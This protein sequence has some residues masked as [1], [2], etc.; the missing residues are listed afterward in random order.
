MAANPP[1]DFP[2]VF[3]PKDFDLQELQKQLEIDEQQEKLTGLVEITNLDMSKTPV[4]EFKKLL[5]Q[6][7]INALRFNSVTFSSDI[8]KLF[9]DDENLIDISFSGCFF[10][11]YDSKVSLSSLLQALSLSQVQSLYFSEMIFLSQD[12]LECANMIVMN[13]NLKSLR[14]LLPLSAAQSQ[15]SDSDAIKYAE[16]LAENSAITEFCLYLANLG[17]IRETG[18]WVDKFA[19][20]LANHKSLCK[21]IQ[22]GWNYGNEDG[23]VKIIEAI[24]KNKNFVEFSLMECRP[25]MS[26]KAV[27]ALMDMVKENVKLTTLKLHES[28]TY[29]CLSILFEIFNRD[30]NLNEFS[31]LS[32]TELE[33]MS[34]EELQHVYDFYEL[35]SKHLDE[36]K[37]MTGSNL[38]LDWEPF[39][40]SFDEQ[41]QAVVNKIKSLAE[42]IN[43]KFTVNRINARHDL[44]PTE[45]ANQILK[46]TQPG[47]FKMSITPVS[48][49][50]HAAF[51]IRQD[52]KAD[53]IREHLNAEVAKLTKTDESDKSGK[54][55]LAAPQEHKLSEEPL[56]LKLHNVVSKA[57]EKID[58]E[59]EEEYQN[60]SVMKTN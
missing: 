3:Q 36:N 35:L 14:I 20:M 38:D 50:K 32:Y 37:I 33:N 9:R 17:P 45:K 53:L 58:Y 46:L 25:L 5:S 48:L 34:L 60:T 55:E 2:L 1:F 44:S 31:L 16:A 30:N 12:H 28:I 10:S 11:V 49:L 59:L 26:K 4:E 13:K 57:D 8:E 42:L 39:G 21:L 27:L 19:N 29:P 22:I 6:Y 18:I 47:K 41:Q 54:L 51:F 24:H 56:A 52:T 43:V 40:N 15:F 7:Q 23:L